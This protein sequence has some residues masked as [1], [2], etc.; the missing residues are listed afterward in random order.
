MDIPNENAIESE[1]EPMDDDIESSNEPAPPPNTSR[2]WAAKDTEQ[3]VSE[4]WSK[5][6]KFYSVI[7]ASRLLDLYRNAYWNRY[8]GGRS[9]G[10]LGIMGENGELTGIEVNHYSNMIQHVQGIIAGQR[11]TFDAKANNADFKSMGQAIMA[12]ALLETIMREKGF[13]KVLL[14]MIDLG[15][16][17]GEGLVTIGWDTNA[18]P[19]YRYAEKGSKES[20]QHVGDVRFW[21]LT[22]LDVVR[23]TM[24]ESFHGHSYQIVRTWGNRYDLMA[25]YPDLADEIESLPNKYNAESAHPRIYSYQWS[26][27]TGVYDTEDVEIWTLFHRKSDAVPDGRMLVFLA[28]DIVLKDGPL[29]YRRIPIFRF[30]PLEQLGT[31]FGYTNFHDLLQL[32]YALNSVMST[33]VSNQ[34]ALGVQN[35]WVPAGSNLTW[36]EI[37]GGLNLVEGGTEPPQALN[38]L[39][40]KPETFQLFDML[41]KGMELISGVN[42]VARGDPAA[43]LKSG[44]AL[45]MVQSM[46]VQFSTIA[47]RSY[48]SCT[49]GMATEVLHQYQDNADLPHMVTITGQGNRSYV[50][51]FVKDDIKNVDRVTIQLGN[52][53]SATVAGR[54]NIAELMAQMGLVKTPQQLDMVLTTGRLEPV[55]QGAQRQMMLIAAENELLMNGKEVHAAIFDDHKLHIQENSTVLDSPEARED[56]TVVKNVT[57]H[58]LSHVELWQR[59]TTDIPALLA[60]KDIPPA[61][62]P[63]MPGMPG[64]PPG[65]PPPALNPRAV[66]KADGGVPLQPQPGTPDTPGAG[67]SN[68]RMPTPPR[69]LPPGPTPPIDIQ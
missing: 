28:P 4:A 3:C 33:I 16:T 30:A 14:E 63:V 42:A 27:V 41:M 57:D 25:K 64:M 58:I 32:Q 12:N 15:L 5:I 53:L 17:F 49:E 37:V 29:P 47:Q 13:E 55:T 48:V 60:A 56:P 46:V 45:T 65:M 2:Y 1:S 6:E 51:E 62:Q 31:T 10:N 44:A 18:G 8:S 22:S 54:Y 39:S 38:L 69:G 52:P 67:K 50:K 7:R 11:P 35:V 40:T 66:A 68:P 19:V 59:A 23:D 43:S 26:Q 24:K 61:P 34:A 9:G 36:K 20:D 21:P